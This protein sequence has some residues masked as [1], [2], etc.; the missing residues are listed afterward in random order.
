MEDKELFA[1]F[2]E[3]FPDT[4]KEALLILDFAERC[5]RIH[6]RY[7][8]GELACMVCTAPISDFGL[9]A[10]YIFACGVKP[11][12]RGKGLFKKTLCEVIGEGCAMLIPEREELYSMYERLGFAPI[13]CIEAFFGG[14][15]SGFRDCG[16]DELKKAYEAAAIYP[17]ISENML[18]YTANAFLSYG[19]SIVTDG[20]AAVFMQDGRATEILASDEQRMLAA[21]AKCKSAYLPCG[22]AQ[23]LDEMGTEYKKIK[24]AAVKNLPDR[25][26]ESIY[27]NNLFN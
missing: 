13:Y 3:C 9:E 11:K 10:E 20:N 19:G 17:K 8:E 22:L 1:L 24:L 2:C 7:I 21:A 23:T 16:R 14:D 6:K 4:Q 15:G 25:K 18:D 12:H 27:I 26:A 5:G